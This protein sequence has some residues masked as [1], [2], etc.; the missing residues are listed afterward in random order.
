[1][2]TVTYRI[3]KNYFTAGNYTQTVKGPEGKRGRV[4]NAMLYDITE[5]FSGTTTGAQVLVG[6][7]ADTNAFFESDATLAT[8]IAVDGCVVLG[9][10]LAGA[11]LEIPRDENLLLTFVACTGTTPTGKAQVD[12]LIEWY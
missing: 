7:A 4:I 2:M 8:S 9:N 1:M 10:K 5:A 6:T 11:P 12:V 3:P